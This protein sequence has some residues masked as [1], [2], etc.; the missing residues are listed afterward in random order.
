MFFSREKMGVRLL[1]ATLIVFSSQASAKKSPISFCEKAVADFLVELAKEQPDLEALKK[2]AADGIAN[3]GEILRNEL[4]AE[5]LEALRKKG[6]LKNKSFT[7]ETALLASTIHYGATASPS[8]ENCKT[9]L[10]FKRPSQ[11]AAKPAP[12]E[13]AD[14]KS[15][16]RHWI[17]PSS[18]VTPMEADLVFLTRFEEA[19]DSVTTRIYSVRRLKDGETK[20]Y[21]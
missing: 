20:T 6:L 8:Y 14:L 12:S 15:I 16:H 10:F 5:F 4:P 17:A 2:L 11:P 1:A 19:G 21:R 9:R 3:Q 13:H 18:W 7:V